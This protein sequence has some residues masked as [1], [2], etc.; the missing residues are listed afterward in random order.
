MATWC[1]KLVGAN[2]VVFGK[3]LSATTV[4]TPDVVVPKGTGVVI[5]G[6]VLDLSP[7]QPN[8][9][10]VSKDSMSSADGVFAFADAD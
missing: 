4:T 7:A 5:K 3:G 6:T 9:P 2:H 8:T 1:L 10:C